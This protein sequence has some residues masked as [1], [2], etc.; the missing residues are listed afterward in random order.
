MLAKGRGLDLFPVCFVF[1]HIRK[2][3]RFGC[4]RIYSSWDI[5]QSEC[6]EWRERCSLFFVSRFYNK[7]LEKVI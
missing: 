3:L 7:Y 2:N 4:R 6:I 1:R 5:S